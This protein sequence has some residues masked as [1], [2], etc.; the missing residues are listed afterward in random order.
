MVTKISIWATFEIVRD[1]RIGTCNLSLFWLHVMLVSLVY[2]KF[3]II[4]FKLSVVIPNCRP[5][6]SDEIYVIDLVATM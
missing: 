1:Q 5:S 2:Y 3:I 4:A 6:Q